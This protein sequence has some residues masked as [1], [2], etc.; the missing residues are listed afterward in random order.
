MAAVIIMAIN[1]VEYSNVN[2]YSS[3][4]SASVKTTEN[5]Q[6]TTESSQQ[7]D[8]AADKTESAVVYEKADGTKSSVFDKEKVMSMMKESDAKTK[9]FQAL[10]EGLLSKQT[11]TY[12]TAVPTTNLKAFYS[13]LEVDE[14]TRLQAQQDISEDGYYGVKQT[15][16]RI[17]DFA[18]AIAGNDP[19]K[20]AEMRSAVE[21]GFEQATRAWGEELPS[22][23]QETYKTVMNGFDEWENS[24]KETSTLAEKI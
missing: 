16:A 21:K 9:Q 19:E 20:I 23:S 17:L 14:A 15:S 11:T 1:P 7:K 10:I 22:I 6:N 8:S 24:V 3:P 5:T 4:T 18:K 12:Y 13:S 2:T